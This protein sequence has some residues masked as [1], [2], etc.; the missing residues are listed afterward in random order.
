MKK[1]FVFLIL[2]TL[3]LVGCEKTPVVPPIPPVINVSYRTVL[4]SQKGKGTV[5]PDTLTK[6]VYG[7]SLTITAT[8]DSG[9]SLYSLRVI[10]TVPH[11]GVEEKEVEIT[12][13]ESPY[14]YILSS[15]KA[16]TEVKFE[17]VETDNLIIS[18]LNPP[19]RLKAIEDFYPNGELFFDW[20]LTELELSLMCYFLYPEGKLLDYLPD[21]SLYFSANWHL[22]EKVLTIGL[23]KF[24]IVE[25]TPTKLVYKMQQVEGG[26]YTL[27]SYERN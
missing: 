11:V 21:G 25:L 24:P 20:P 22:V 19:W 15:I 3:L 4:V 1:V 7:E 5:N 17:F 2:A 16:N 18:V 8:P 9:H 26:I 6:V 14:T 12:P 23:M 27:Y 10:S 13:T